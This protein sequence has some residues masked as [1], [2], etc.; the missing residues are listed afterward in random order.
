MRRQLYG[1]EDDRKFFQW[2]QSQLKQTET[3]LENGRAVL[4]HLEA[5][6]INVACDDPGAAIG[7]QLA[8]PLL[9]ERLDAKAQEFARQKAAQAEEDI[10]KMEVGSSLVACVP[11]LSGSCPRPPNFYSLPPPL[12][13]DPC[14]MVTFACCLLVGRFSFKRILMCHETTETEEIE[15]EARLLPC[16]PLP[17][18]L[19]PSHAHQPGMIQTKYLL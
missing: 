13:P 2:V 7:A 16:G 8:L 3:R 15:V 1:D 5:Q 10:I 14:V 11:W 19:P 9:Q 18:L 17:R 4:H 12:L 6:L